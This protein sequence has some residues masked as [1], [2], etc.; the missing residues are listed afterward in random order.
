MTL[1]V[2]YVAT[3]PFV[4]MA[5]HSALSVISSTER[6][7]DITVDL[8][9]DSA[10]LDPAKAGTQRLQDR[11]AIDINLRRMTNVIRADQA[12]SMVKD[13]MFFRLVLPEIFS[14]AANLLYL[15]ADTIITGD[16]FS[17]IAERPSGFP[18]SACVDLLSPNRIYD[19]FHC[20]VHRQRWQCS[21][22][23][24]GLLLFDCLLWRDIQ[25]DWRALIPDAKKFL[26]P[27]QD[28]LNLVLHDR[29]GRLPDEWN[30]P[31]ISS[32]VAG[33][34]STAHLLGYSSTFVGRYTREEALE[35][36]RKA[37]LYHFIDKS[38]PEIGEYPEVGPAYPAFAAIKNI[39]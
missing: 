32:I 29:I 10:D 18:V 8:F 4:R 7:S 2:A 5:L 24:S 17:L 31:P 21:Y 14:D 26:L 39:F 19:H 34:E 33:G 37:K 3:G 11:H 20:D 38:K 30:V 1:R 25:A 13:A 12:T 36:E 16:I 23:N 27:D 35:L 28:V 22:F 6:K 15:D 9:V